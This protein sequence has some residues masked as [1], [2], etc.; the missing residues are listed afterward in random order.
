M[1][2]EAIKLSAVHQVLPLGGIASEVVRR[3]GS[4]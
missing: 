4:T 1:P 2:A 3:A